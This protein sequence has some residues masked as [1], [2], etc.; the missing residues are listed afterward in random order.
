[1]IRLVVIALVLAALSYWFYR[2][3][4][5]ATGMSRRWSRVGIGALV[6][7][8][9]SAVIGVGSG[10]VFDTSWARPAGF[11]GWVWVAAGFYLT[12]GL[13]V[14]GAV[15]WGWHRIRRTSPPA[16]ARRIALRTAT[17][18]L[19]L[20]SVGTAMY[21]VSEASRPQVVYVQIALDRLPEGFDGTRLALV[22]D[23]HVGPARGSGFTQ[24]VVDL[25]NAQNP[26]LIVLPGDF[27]DG[28]VAKVAPDLA[29]LGDLSAPLG[30][31]GVS[32]N[33]EFYADDGGR[34]LDVWDTLGIRT[35]R[36]ERVEVQRNGSV[37]DIAGVHDYSST[38]PYRPNLPVTLDG[39]DP[40]R[41]VLLLAHQP[42]HVYEAAEHGVDLQVS[43]HTHGGQM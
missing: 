23:L 7:L 37:I 13:A 8:W 22:T 25:V 29:P 20:A 40:A 26:D 24:E 35:L 43:G 3:L 36:N 18:A 10:E 38:D 33:H 16:P 42:K 39:R 2:R 21:G 11:V 34:W 41:L 17:A 12:V 5:L 1:M 14:I 4:I 27:V 32:G 31:F 6:A 9:I 28:T 30:V 19:V 15:S